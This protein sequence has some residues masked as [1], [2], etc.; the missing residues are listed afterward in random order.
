MANSEP[1]NAT[2]YNNLTV[3]Q[4]NELK[5]CRKKDS[6]ALLVIQQAVHESIFPRIAAA[7]KSKDAWKILK[8]EYQGT[9]KRINRSAEKVIEQAFQSKL[10][11]SPEKLKSQGSSVEQQFAGSGSLHDGPSHS[12]TSMEELLDPPTSSMEMSPSSQTSG[13]SSSPSSPNSTP[14][15]KN[16][17]PLQKQA[18]WKDGIKP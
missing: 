12:S 11:V 17:H 3:A 5:D 4:K 2:A 10:E 7:N 15:R 13:A 8:D 1:E 18:Q 6:K 16:Q 9:D 14:T